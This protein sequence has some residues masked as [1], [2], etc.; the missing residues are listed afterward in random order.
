M[1]YLTLECNN[2]DAKYS[3]EFNEELIVGWEPTKCPFCGEDLDEDFLDDEN[4]ELD[5]D[6]DDEDE[7]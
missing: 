6:Y 3:V 5:E 2:C 7:E 1:K 4:E